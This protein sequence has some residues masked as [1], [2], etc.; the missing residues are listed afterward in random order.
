M[1]ATDAYP[2]IKKVLSI[3]DAVIRG[4][5]QTEHMHDNRHFRIQGKDKMGTR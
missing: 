3:N 1:L 5:D 4:L 2:L